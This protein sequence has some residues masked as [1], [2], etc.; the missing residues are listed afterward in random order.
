[1][2]RKSFAHTNCSIARALEVVGEW[3]TILVLREAFLGVR[4]FEDFHE[5]VGVARNILAARLRH[6]VRHGV[7]ARARYQ[8]RPPRHEYWLTDKGRDLFPVIVALMNWGDR[9]ATPA[10]GPPVVLAE[11]ATGKPLAPR[12]VCGKSGKPVELSTTLAIPGPGADARTRRR[13]EEIAEAIRH[14]PRA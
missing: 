3:W 5:R 13:L 10:A 1:M 8:E 14:P 2:K 11:R 9:W 7:L 4:R 12:L 6:L